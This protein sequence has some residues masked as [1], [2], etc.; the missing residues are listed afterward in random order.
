LRR[1]AITLGQGGATSQKRTQPPIWT[2]WVIPAGT[3]RRK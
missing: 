2:D 1:V 3:I